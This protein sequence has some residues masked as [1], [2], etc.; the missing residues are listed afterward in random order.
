[1]SFTLIQIVVIRNHKV[2]HKEAVE[3]EPNAIA[4]SPSEAVVAIG[5]AGVSEIFR[6]LAIENCL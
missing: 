1:M 4:L 3:Y 6:I 2:V 5:C